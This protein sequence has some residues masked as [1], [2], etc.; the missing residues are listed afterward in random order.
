[1]ILYDQRLPSSPAQV[2]H[3]PATDSPERSHAERLELLRQELNSLRQ[4]LNRHSDT[5]ITIGVFGG[6][7]GGKTSWATA[8]FSSPAPSPAFPAASSRVRVVDTP[9]LTDAVAAD[10]PTVDVDEE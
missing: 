9:G 2:A 8:L 5:A 10:R 1:M 4:Q 7:S 6:Y 3:P